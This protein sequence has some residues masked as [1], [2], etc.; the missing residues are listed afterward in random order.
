MIIKCHEYSNVHKIS[1]PFV[2]QLSM[3]LFASVYI[4][5]IQLKQK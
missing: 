5:T 2:E 3:I 1:K 4:Q